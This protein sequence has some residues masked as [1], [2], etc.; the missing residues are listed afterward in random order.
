M[1]CISHTKH[2]R[3]EEIGWNK[4][5]MKQRGLRVRLNL[6]VKFLFHYHLLSWGYL[7][8]IFPSMEVMPKPAKLAVVT[9]LESL[10]CPLN[11]I[12][13]EPCIP[14]CY[15]HYPI[16]LNFLLVPFGSFW[17]QQLQ[18]FTYLRINL[19]AK[20][21]QIASLKNMVLKNYDAVG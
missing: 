17:L 12:I 6:Q 13:P 21:S 5:Q 7:E 2:Y 11:L 14:K 10:S 16:P 1:I 18:L 9:T 4:A 20:I 19:A 3:E 8:Y 15:P